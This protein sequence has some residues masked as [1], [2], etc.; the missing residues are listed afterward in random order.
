[1]VLVSYREL[2]IVSTP[3]NTP[4]RIIDWTCIP[5][6]MGYTFKEGGDTEMSMWLTYWWEKWTKT[7]KIDVGVC[8]L[9]IEDNPVDV[10]LFERAVDIAGYISLVATTGRLGIKIAQESTPALIIL[11]YGLPDMTGAEVLK[12]LKG[13]KK[14]SRGPVMVL[15]ILDSGEAVIRSFENGADQYFP[16]PIDTPTLVRQIKAMVKPIEKGQP[17]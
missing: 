16:K 9:I 17:R 7:R 6:P 1:M 3:Q 12:A 4:Q 10:K 15:S 11:D 2:L 8:V 13:H 14:T 5:S